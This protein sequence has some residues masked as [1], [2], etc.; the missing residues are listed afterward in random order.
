MGL[1]VQASRIRH[2]L[3]ANRG[4]YSNPKVDA[5]YDQLNTTLDPKARIGVHQQFVK[6]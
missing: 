1:H 2:A 4:G 6:S 3:P 5:L